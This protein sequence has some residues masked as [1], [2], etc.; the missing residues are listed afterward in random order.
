MD[1]MIFDGDFLVEN[2][3]GAGGGGEKAHEDVDR[4][5]FAGAVWAEE[6]GD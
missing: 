1:F 6:A 4:G 3:G 2:L 5:G